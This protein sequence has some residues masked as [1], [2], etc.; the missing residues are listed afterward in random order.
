MKTPIKRSLLVIAAVLVATLAVFA[1][2][3]LREALPERTGKELATAIMQDKELKTELMNRMMKDKEGCSKMMSGN[4]DMMKMCSKMMAGMGNSSSM[5][6]MM[7]NKN[8]KPEQ[9]NENETQL[10]EAGES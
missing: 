3:G 1:Q 9:E 2:T 10:E 7:I 8:E 5:C 4:E 6:S